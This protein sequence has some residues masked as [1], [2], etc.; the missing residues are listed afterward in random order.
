M[1][2]PHLQFLTY[3]LTSFLCPT[4]KLSEQFFRELCS[5]NCLEF[6]YIHNLTRHLFTVHVNHRSGEGVNESRDC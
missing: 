3:H 1:F 2:A 4:S 5:D 6:K